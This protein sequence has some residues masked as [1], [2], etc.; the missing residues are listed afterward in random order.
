MVWK[1]ILVSKVSTVNQDLQGL[2]GHRVSKEI[3]E[4]RVNQEKAFPEKREQP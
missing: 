4:T 2:R 1:E 3:K